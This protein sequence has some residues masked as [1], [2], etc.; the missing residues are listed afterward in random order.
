MLLHALLVLR[1]GFFDG[2]VLHTEK[3]TLFAEALKFDMQVCVNVRR[4]GFLIV[5]LIGLGIGDV[6]AVLAFDFEVPLRTG[7]KKSSS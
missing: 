5:V 3:T 4:C 6:E 1:L 7:V 2:V